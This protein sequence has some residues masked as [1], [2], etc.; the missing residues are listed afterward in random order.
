MKIF[1]IISLCILISILLVLG[2]YL[3]VGYIAYR[4]CLHRKGTI[5]KLIG[6]NFDD[7]LKRL[8]VDKSYFD[9]GFEKIKLKNQENFDIFAFYK[10]NGDTNKVV[11]LAHGYGGKHCEMANYA[12]IFEKRGYDIFA[13][14]HRCHGES[15]GKDLTMGE[16]ESQDLLLWINYLVQLNPHYKIV[17]HGLSMGASTVC[18]TCGEKLPSNVVLAIEDCGYDNAYKQF[19][20]VY[21]KR[22]FSM[23]LIFKIFYSFTKKTKNL[24]LK[25][26]DPM[27]ELKN[28]KIPIMFIHGDKDTFVPTEMIFTLSSSVPDQR[29]HIYL[30]ENADHAEAYM[31]NPQK[32]ENEVNKF[33]NQYYM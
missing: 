16:K 20:S 5:V 13:I 11:L 29:K 7:N 2:L 10:K 32:Y 25:K 24:D 28:S 4:L 12:K 8:N 22:K 27:Q 30:A 33:L 23:G 1:W 9:E 14:D 15:E 21:F 31:V 19:S 17:L 3:L 6:K 26:V 18:I